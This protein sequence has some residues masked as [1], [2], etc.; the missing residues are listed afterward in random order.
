M[1][2]K[3]VVQ[4][5]DQVL[6]PDPFWL[7]AVEKCDASGNIPFHVRLLWHFQFL[8]PHGEPE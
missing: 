7:L 4:Y 3:T 8:I 2:T 6:P 1:N 5:N